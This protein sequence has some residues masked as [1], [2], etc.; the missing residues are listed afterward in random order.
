MSGKTGFIYDLKTITIRF[1]IGS[2]WFRFQ[3]KSRWRPK[4]AMK[5]AHFAAL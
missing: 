5:A 3:N 2:P 1:R 4:I